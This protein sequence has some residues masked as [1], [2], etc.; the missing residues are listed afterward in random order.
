MLV[1]GKAKFLLWL[2]QLETEKR[3]AGNE[4]RLLFLLLLRGDSSLCGS[5]NILILIE[6]FIL[7]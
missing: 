3:L 1:Q 2:D 5:H 7:S 6:T 4:G